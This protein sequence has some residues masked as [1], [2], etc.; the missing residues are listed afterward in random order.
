MLWFKG[1]CPNI[2]V[3]TNQLLFHAL[4]FVSFYYF[5]KG[6]VYFEMQ[7]ER[8][9]RKSLF[10]LISLPICPDS[11]KKYVQNFMYL[12]LSLPL[13]ALSWVW[14]YGFIKWDL[15]TPIPYGIRV[16]ITLARDTELVADLPPRVWKG[17]GF[18]KG[19]AEGKVGKSHTRYSRYLIFTWPEWQIFL[20]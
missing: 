9:D 3:E 15:P 7:G 14:C 16:P 10:I 1:K 2:R 13:Q 20:G 17:A 5:L 8:P 12:A 11:K 6:L 19:I 18:N 4:V